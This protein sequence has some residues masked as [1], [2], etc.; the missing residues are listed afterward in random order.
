MHV[1]ICGGVERPV[2]LRSPLVLI[3]MLLLRYFRVDW[4]GVRM[5]LKTL[6]TLFILIWLK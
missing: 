2:L 6:W 3:L 1:I 5:L 4:S